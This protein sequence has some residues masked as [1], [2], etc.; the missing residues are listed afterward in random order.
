MADLDLSLVLPYFNPGEAL[1]STLEESVAVL[2]GT[3]A[4][5]EVIAVSDGS[6]DGSER[7]IEGLFPADLVHVVLPARRG[8]GEALRSGFQ[9]ARGRYVGFIDADGDIPPALLADFVRLVR[10]SAPDVVIGSKRVPG[11]QVVYPPLRRLYSWSYQQLVRLAFGLKVTDTQAG[12]KLVRRKVLADV[13]PRTVVEGFAF[14][15]ELLV[16]AERLGYTQ[17]IEA[18]VRIGRRFRSTISLRAVASTLGETAAIWWRL[19]VTHRY[20]R[21]ES[22]PSTLA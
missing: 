8:K 5:F 12:I 17:V 21:L 15:L 14:D 19:R 2:R 18:P 10:T 20:G 3:G 16:L 11:S 22:G 13:L 7:S 6:T 9:I 4:T 1:R